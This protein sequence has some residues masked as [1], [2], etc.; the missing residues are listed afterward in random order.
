VQVTRIRFSQYF[1]VA[2]CNRNNSARGRILGGN[3]AGDYQT[4]F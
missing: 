4:L 2:P 3:A 1:Y